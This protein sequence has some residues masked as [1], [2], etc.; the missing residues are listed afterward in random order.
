MFHDQ[1]GVVPSVIPASP[2]LDTTSPSPD[3]NQCAICKTQQKITAFTGCRVLHYCGTAHQKAH[4]FSHK[5]VCKA[6]KTSTEQVWMAMADIKRGMDAAGGDARSYFASSPPE[7]EAHL[8]FRYILSR[9]L[10]K[11][12][13][14]VGVQEGLRNLLEVDHLSSASRREADSTASDFIPALYLRLGRDR[15]C[16]AFLKDKCKSAEVDDLY[17]Y[18]IDSSRT[19]RPHPN[20]QNL[21]LARAAML[22]VFKLR[23]LRDLRDLDQADAALGNKLPAELFNE[24][25]S[26]LVGEATKTNPQLMQAIDKRKSLKWDVHKIEM[27][28]QNL[29]EHIDDLNEEYFDAI[30]DPEKYR[31]MQPAYEPELP[32][33]EALAQTYDAW[34]ETPGAFAMFQKIRSRDIYTSVGADVD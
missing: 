3:K 2:S 9:N 16:L 24:C 27:D 28:I 8:H 25:R 1:Y 11:A 14:L 7:A 23:I 12:G 15:E 30:A 10:I 4:W 34:A 13:T 32:I 18:H 20:A 5:R 29:G 33:T 17:R 31:K 22:C 21:N 19:A 26:Y 6:V